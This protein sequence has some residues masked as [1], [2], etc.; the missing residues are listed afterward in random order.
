MDAKEAVWE[1][2][3]WVGRDVRIVRFTPGGVQREERPEIYIPL[4]ERPEDLKNLRT[5][6][7][8]LNIFDL[9]RYIE[10]IEEEGYDPYTYKVDLYNKVATPFGMVILAIL[11]TFFGAVERRGGIPG[12][13]I[14]A[15]GA[16]F[17]YWLVQALSTAL[18]YGGLLPPV[19][20]SWLPNLAFGTLGG[21]LLIQISRR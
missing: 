21:S 15:L 10:R 8:A 16:A 12:A 13:I 14:L 1:K 3:R 9:K 17:S 4:R 7:G 2:G 19:V 5:P 18:G 11:G 6:G 20:A